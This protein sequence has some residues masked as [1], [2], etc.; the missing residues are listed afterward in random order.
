MERKN[1]ECWSN[2]F[3][4]RKNNKLINKNSTINKDIYL[5]QIL[6]GVKFKNLIIQFF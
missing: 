2:L 3:A 1:F 6:V 4:N 5:I